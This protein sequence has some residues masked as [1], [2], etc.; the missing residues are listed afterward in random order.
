[1]FTTDATNTPHKKVGSARPKEQQVESSEQQEHQE[2]A[3]RPEEV[4]AEPPQPQREQTDDDAASARGG[5]MLGGPEAVP[6]PR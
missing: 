3:Q 6:T 4:Q 1:M 2:Q 5:P